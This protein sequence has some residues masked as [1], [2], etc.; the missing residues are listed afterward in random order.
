MIHVPSLILDVDKCK[1][2]IRDMALKAKELKV[3][4]RPHFKTHQS[5]EIG[6]WF[7]EHGV[8]KITVSSLEMAE[9]FLPEWKDITVAFP[10]NI[11]EI[12][13]IN[14]LAEKIELNL[15]V[16]SI[17]TAKFLIENLTNP[18]GFFIKIDAGY[19]RTGVQPKDGS[20]IDDILKISE[21]SEKLIFKG[22]LAHS[23]H[24]YKCQNKADVLDIHQRCMSTLVELKE[25]YENEYSNLILSLGDTPSCSIAE[26]FEGIDE[27]RPGN[28]VF[29]DLMQN[30]IGSSAIDQIAVALAC[31][32]VAIHDDRN[33]IVVYGGG[34]HF[35][36]E[37]LE[38]EK[39]GRIY[40]RIVEK[41][42]NSWGDLIPDMFIKSL[43]Q[44]HG[45]ISVRDDQ[46]KNYSIGDYILALPIHSCMT[47]NLV[48]RYKTTDGKDILMMNSW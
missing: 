47:A 17:E 12:E 38:N 36:K 4:F 30:K 37:R 46:I 33:E 28:F 16:E 19:H 22:F 5:L 41:N 43:S 14:R 1:K 15:L 34:V 20:I 25:K 32:I 31:P 44:E 42:G 7:K 35:S 29:Y 21:I 26:A 3:T 24:T 13:R 11:L 9:Y 10:T 6:R 23:G 27:I 39:E 48:K 40:G 8:N 18:V 45:I 2:N